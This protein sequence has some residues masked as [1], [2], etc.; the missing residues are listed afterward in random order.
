MGCT[1]IRVWHGGQGTKGTA[2]ED[3]DT[4]TA[5]C[6]PGLSYTCAA[7]N[8]PSAGLHPDTTVTSSTVRKE[9]EP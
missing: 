9:K 2:Q 1:D 3:S 4:V 5:L 7:A 6:V 8:C